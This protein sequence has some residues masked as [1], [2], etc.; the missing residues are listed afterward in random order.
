MSCYLGD[1]KKG[2][3]VYFCWTMYGS[4]GGSV[5]R[6]SGEY[7]GTIVI[8]RANMMGKLEAGE[9]NCGL[10]EYTSF[11]NLTGV[12]SGIINLSS[13]PFYEAGRDYYIVLKTAVIEGLTI[14]A[15]LGMFSIENRHASSDLFQK[16]AKVLVNKAIQDKD[17]GAIDYYDDD[18]E[19][20]LL[21]H[22][23]IEDETNITRTAS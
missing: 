8:Y 3:K 6:G 16:A 4:N 7:G 5:D 18:G 9:N 23:P 19:T 13:H 17:T 10:T 21:R 11:D 15:L 14:N 20:V 2:S 22:R 12:N 1:F